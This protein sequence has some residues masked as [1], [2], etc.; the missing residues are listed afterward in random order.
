MNDRFPLIH[1]QRVAS[2]FFSLVLC[3]LTLDQKIRIREKTLAKDLLGFEKQFTNMRN[4]V[5]AC[6]SNVV[7]ELRSLLE[8]RLSDQ[9]I[10]DADAFA[11]ADFVRAY[12]HALQAQEDQAFARSYETPRTTIRE[13]SNDDLPSGTETN[14]P[15]YLRHRRHH[16]P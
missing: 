8:N 11:T 10:T 5:Y 4:S 15:S 12:A 3:W 6:L 13:R 9:E 7:D 16:R 2:E 1:A 14:Q